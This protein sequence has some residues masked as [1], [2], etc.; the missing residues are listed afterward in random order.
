MIKRV[1]RLHIEYARRQAYQLKEL[2]ISLLKSLAQTQNNPIKSRLI[3]THKQRYKARHFNISR[4]QN[5]C[6]VTGRSRSVIYLTGL[7]R[8]SLKRYALENKVQNLKVGSW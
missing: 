4:H 5:L 7:S 3:Y 6:L 1:E 2:K 8:H